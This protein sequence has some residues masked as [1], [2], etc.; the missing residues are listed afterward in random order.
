MAQA[1]V[2]Q[3]FPDITLQATNGQNIRLADLKGLAVI[4]IHPRT[5]P[6]DGT[7]IPGWSEIPGAKGCTPQSCGFRDHYTEL[8]D[9]GVAQVYGLSTQSSDYQAE[10][11]GR[12]H[13]PFPLMSDI[14]LKLQKAL[15]LPIFK[16][17]GMHLLHRLV[18]IVSDG[19]IEHVV[20][21]IKDPAGNAE[22]VLEYIKGR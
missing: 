1:L 9:A 3:Q 7:A 6:P 15:D 2:G 21:N 17:G 14:N 18:L 19:K 4:Y 20:E 5:S 22:D 13:L 8:S 12:L 16:A 10:V 11:V